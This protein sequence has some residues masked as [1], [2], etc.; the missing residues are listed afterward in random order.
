M[1]YRIVDKEG[2][3]WRPVDPVDLESTLRL[4]WKLGMLNE[5]LSQEETEK[6]EKALLIEK[7]TS[8]KIFPSGEKGDNLLTDG[9][10]IETEEEE[11]S[12][13]IDDEMENG[14]IES[15]ACCF[16]GRKEGE[17][18]PALKPYAFNLFIPF[19]NLSEP[20]RRQ[21]RI[22]EFRLICRGC[23]TKWSGLISLFRVKIPSTPKF[24]DE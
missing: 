23:Y 8:C 18:H 19:S 2:R 13:G 9:E 4:A 12:E 15:P 5:K 14:E 7:D 17:P 6:D 3:L 11:K 1:D 21:I 24:E 22:V 16:C 20:F 10:E